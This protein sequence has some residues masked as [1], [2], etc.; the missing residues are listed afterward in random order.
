MSV[1][2]TTVHILYILNIIIEYFTVR[3]ISIFWLCFESVGLDSPSERLFLTSR[4]VSGFLTWLVRGLV[5]KAFHD[6]GS[7]VVLVT[8]MPTY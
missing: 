5:W 8:G 7:K 4:S 1:Y 6:V 3:C 2:S